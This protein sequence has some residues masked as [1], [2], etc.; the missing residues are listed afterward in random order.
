[1]RVYYMQSKRIFLIRTNISQNIVL[2]KMLL[3]VGYPYDWCWS[4]VVVLTFD[5]ITFP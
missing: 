2:Y 1:M 3:V 4:Q 5:N